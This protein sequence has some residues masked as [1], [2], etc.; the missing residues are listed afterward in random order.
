MDVQYLANAL[1]EL[2]GEEYSIVRDKD[3]RDS[4]S[5]DAFV[6]EVFGHFCFWQTLHGYAFG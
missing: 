4:V 3:H 5:E 2:G 6:N 1:K